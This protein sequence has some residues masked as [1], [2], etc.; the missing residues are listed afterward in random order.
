MKV[1]KIGAM[2]MLTGAMTPK[3]T[4]LLKQIKLLKAVLV[5]MP[6]LMLLLAMSLST[7]V[8]T[9]STTLMENG[10]STLMK[11]AHGLLFLPKRLMEPGGH[12]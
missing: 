3:V 7:L 12:I 6:L 9:P 8:L 4:G 5:L 11:V 1:L 10:P 2:L